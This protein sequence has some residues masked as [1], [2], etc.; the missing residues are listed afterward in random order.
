MNPVVKLAGFAAA[1]ALLFAGAA[2]AGSQ[3]DVR[4]G[5]PAEPEMD[6]MAGAHGEMAAQPVRGLAVSEGGLTLELARTTAPRGKRFELARIR[7][8]RELVT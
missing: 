3:A 7:C 2:L 5:K 8:H 1:L 6:T 4:A